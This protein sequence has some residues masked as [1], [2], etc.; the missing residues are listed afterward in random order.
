MNLPAS[1]LRKKFLD[2]R[3]TGHL[4]GSSVLYEFQRL[5]NQS[6]EQERGTHRLVAYVLAQVFQDL[7][8][9]QDGQAIHASEAKA[10]F[11]KLDQPIFRCIDYICSREYG[12][13]AEE[14]LTAMSNAVGAAF[15]S[16]DSS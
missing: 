5:C 16:G 15:S 13:S 9:R 1:R 11:E 6:C 3:E 14:I 2:L 7:A 10:L 4:G 8:Q 12:G